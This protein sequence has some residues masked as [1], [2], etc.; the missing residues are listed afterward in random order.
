MENGRKGEEGV[1]DWRLD[2]RRPNFGIRPKA[3]RVLSVLGP[4]FTLPS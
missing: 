4:N 1:P 3:Q 2:G